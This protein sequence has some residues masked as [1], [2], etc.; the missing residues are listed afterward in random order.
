LGAEARASGNKNHDDIHLEEEEGGIENLPWKRIREHKI[1]MEND[2]EGLSVKK[3]EI[4]K[5][6]LDRKA[7]RRGGTEKMTRR[8]SKKTYFSTVKEKG[9]KR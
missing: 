5:R 7:K 3:P 9:G 2:A 8:V 1:T 4:K 6:R